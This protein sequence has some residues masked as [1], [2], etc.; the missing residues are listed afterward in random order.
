VKPENVFCNRGSYGELNVKLLDFGVAKVCSAASLVEA[1]GAGTLP[2][3]PAYMAPEQVRGDATDERT[4]VYAFGAVMYEMLCGRPPLSARNIGELVIRLMAVT[5]ERPS[6]ASGRKPK[7]SPAI[8]DLVMRCLAK[9]PSDRPISMRAVRGELLAAT[10]AMNAP[11]TSMRLDEINAI[12]RRGRDDR[13][14]GGYNKMRSWALEGSR[15]GA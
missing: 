4:D 11:T 6:K 2:G 14:G 7:V 10:D 9:Y 1:T 12:L 3:T 13:P 8:D 15:V 5:P